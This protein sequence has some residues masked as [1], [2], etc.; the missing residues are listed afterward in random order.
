MA[1]SVTYLL[2]EDAS[3]VNGHSLL[4]DGGYTAV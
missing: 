4:V 2:S 1:S 3:Y